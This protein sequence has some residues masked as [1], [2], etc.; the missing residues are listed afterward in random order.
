MRKNRRPVKCR[1]VVD[2]TCTKERYET[3]TV[4]TDAKGVASVRVM[5]R[6]ILLN[7]D[8][9]SYDMVWTSI[10]S[11]STSWDAVKKELGL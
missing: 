3:R 5:G 11:A 4:Y 9:F 8:N 2:G 7:A 10:S 6:K 1:V